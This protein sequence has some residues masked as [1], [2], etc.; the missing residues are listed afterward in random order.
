MFSV[1]FIYEE[2]AEN[3]VKNAKYSANNAQKKLVDFLKVN[4]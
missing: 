3:C 1:S 4:S 2:F